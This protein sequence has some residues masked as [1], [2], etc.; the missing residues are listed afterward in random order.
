MRKARVKTPKRRLTL[1][2]RWCPQCGRVEIETELQS[3]PI[4]EGDP[5]C[6]L[7]QKQWHRGT[8]AEC[9]QYFAGRFPYIAAS[10]IKALWAQALYNARDAARREVR[11][12]D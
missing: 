6:G 9:N 12:T 10:V 2:L 7:E 11:A 4:R 5:E 8:L 1:L 3:R